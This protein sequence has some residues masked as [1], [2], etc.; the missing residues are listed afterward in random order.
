VNLAS[1]IEALTKEHGAAALASKT[2][3]AGAGDAFAWTETPAL[4][5]KGKQAPVK[6]F[7]PARKT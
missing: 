6:A 2:T 4:V 1:R 7:V 5:V 3:R